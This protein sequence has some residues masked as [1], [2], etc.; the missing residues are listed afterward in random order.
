MLSM[1]ERKNKH[2]KLHSPVEDSCLFKHISKVDI[3]VEEIWIQS[4][5][6]LEMMNCEPNLTLCVEYTTEIAPGDGKV[7]TSF[8]GF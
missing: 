1:E 6:L 7:W 8:D 4:D 3:S 5:S 2:Q